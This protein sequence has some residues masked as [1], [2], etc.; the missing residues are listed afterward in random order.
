[1]VTERSQEANLLASESSEHQTAYDFSTIAASNQSSDSLDAC[2]DNTAPRGDELSDSDFDE[3]DVSAEDDDSI[4]PEED[5]A[6][7]E[8]ILSLM[9]ESQMSLDELLATY[10]IPS[11]VSNHNNN[12]SQVSGGRSGRLRSARRTVT[13]PSS[14]TSLQESLESLPPA[15]KPRRAPHTS[16]CLDSE[17]NDILAKRTI[18]RNKPISS[19]G[20]SIIHS[21][22]DVDALVDKNKTNKSPLSCLTAFPHSHSVPCSHNTSPISVDISWSNPSPSTTTPKHSKRITSESLISSHKRTSRCH[23]LRS[24]SK[25][26]LGIHT[27]EFLDSA[28]PNGEKYL[29]REDT[30]TNLSDSEVDL[31]NEYSKNEQ[32]NEG[33]NKFE[34]N[35][36]Y[37]SRFWKSAITGQET[38]PSYNSDED[39]DYCP[40]EDSGRDWK[41][42]IKVGDEYQANVPMFILPPSTVEN[43]ICDDASYNGAERIFQESI[44]VWKPPE[45]LYESDVARYERLYAHAVV[46]ALPTERTIDDEEALF[47]LMRCDYDVD[48]ALQ[49]LQLKAVPAAE[50]PG[51]LDSWS[52]SDCTAFEKSFALYGKDFRQI[53][54]TR[55]RHKTISELI[56]FYYLWKKTARHDEFARTYRRDKKKS[57]HP[58]ITDFMDCLAMEQEILAES[59]MQ[60]VSDVIV[61]TGRSNVDIHSCHKSG[62]SNSVQKSY[63]VQLTPVSNESPVEIVDCQMHSLF[64]SN[65]DQKRIIFADCSETCA[66]GSSLNRPKGLSDDEMV[67]DGLTSGIPSD[68]SSINRSKL[69]SNNLLNTSTIITTSNNESNNYN[70]T[71]CTKQSGHLPNSS[72]TTRSTRTS[73]TVTV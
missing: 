71:Y 67:D 6:D 21:S 2:L 41:G 11:S 48:E 24:R 57:S 47:L 28:T 55:L 59:Y 30:G 63:N 69:K 15:K 14:V 72:S 22:S 66:A 27:S 53:R 16:G 12:N 18:S 54:E 36:G 29:E 8:E 33:G 31:E 50:V 3:R 51:Y 35:E 10:G 17:F 58:N 65:N 26:S 32:T 68:S 49:R 38:P 73:S 52:E 19:A 40:S 62:N 56:H 64:N 43:Q 25:S 5:A 9:K 1:M 23:I 34:V 60:N 44:L 42:E 7:E 37:S 4:P 46:S 70:W 61:S 13:P 20:H 39:E 45:K